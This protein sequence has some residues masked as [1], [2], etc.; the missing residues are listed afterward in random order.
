MFKKFD[1]SQ[2]MKISQFKLNSPMIINKK[3]S[4]ELFLV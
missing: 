2:K 1:F 4:C 3:K